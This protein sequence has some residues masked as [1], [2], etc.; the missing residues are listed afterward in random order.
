MKRS[1]VL[2]FLMNMLS[3]MGYSIVSPLFPLLGEKGNLGEDLLGFLI[4]IYALSSFFL[5]PFS[6]IFCKKFGRI[7]ILYISTFGEATC[8][9]LYGIL[10]FINS[11]YLLI[12]MMFILR[13]IHGICAGF[14][15]VLVYSLVSSISSEDEVQL[16]LGYME[17][18]WCIG[19][20]GGPLCAAIF[21]KLGGYYLPFI[22]LGLIL[23]TSVY[24]THIISEEKIESDEENDKQEHSFMKL[25]FNVNIILT[26]GSIALGVIVNTFYFPSLTNHLTTNYGLSVSVSSLFF[27]VGLIFYM[28]FLQ[29]LNLLTDRFGFHGTTCIGLLMGAIGSLLVYPVPPF[30]QNIFFILFGL[31]LIGG[32]GG[33]IYVTGLIN[34]SHYI[35]KIDPTIDEFTANDIGS[36]MY[37]FINNVGDFVGPVLGGFI[38]K[39][40][41]FKYSCLIISILIFVY[42]GIF[43]NHFIDT[44]K[45]EY[46]KI[47]GKNLG[48]IKNEFERLSLGKKDNKL[49]NSYDRLSI[50]ELMCFKTN[51]L[52]RR[53]SFIKKHNKFNS[54]NGS[55][56][57]SLTN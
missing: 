17:V 47:P 36:A 40:L 12:I 55:L 57:S 2:L 13:I 30:P 22:V 52:S 16:A 37:Q 49:N 34:L 33:P 45:N 1:Q 26:L 39:F 27:I 14:V 21:Y 46:Y 23:F 19:L 48:E 50:T 29:F 41:G 11:F 20:S 38:S 18:A 54:S 42:L 5:I 53:N 35:R 25:L 10:S 44:I 24:F 31:C 28:I 56:F 15:G 4:S 51:C 32:L 7:N 9:L 3:G 8:M 6:P 43:I